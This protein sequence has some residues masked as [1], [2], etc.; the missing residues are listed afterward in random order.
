MP[1]IDHAVER[2]YALPP[3]FFIRYR[4]G[5]R[6]RRTIDAPTDYTILLILDGRMLWHSAS[7][8]TDEH[9][10][11]TGAE[12]ETGESGSVCGGGALLAAPGDSLTATAD[13]SVECLTVTLSPVFVLD[14]A[15][16]ARMMRAD[17]FISFNR[18]SVEGDDR[19]Y[20]LARDL[21]DELIE[22]VAGQAVAVGALIEQALVHV[23]RRYAVVRRS[24][25]LELSRAGLTDRRIRRAVELMH[26]HLEREL[27]LEE[28]ASAAHLSPFHFSRLF[29]KLTGAT[30]HSY[31]AA[32]RISRA[33][34]LLAQTDLSVTEIGSRVGYA[35]S[36]HFSKAFR[37]ST[38]LSPRAFRA[39]LVGR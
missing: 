20:R 2:I 37:Q 7:A 25:Q 38:G 8:A 3:H 24:D 23:L 16:R 21:A 14:C 17:S 26:A 29:K 18:L 39:S 33:Q 4:R 10:E 34:T 6:L 32:L 13:A 28:I 15:A 9:L 19:L 31:L 1:S 36:S 12:V 22:E 30:P 5:R 11:S 27:P 35:S